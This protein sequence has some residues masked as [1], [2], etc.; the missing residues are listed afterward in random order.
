MSLILLSHSL[1]PTPLNLLKIPDC[2]PILPSV[3]LYSQLL[4]FM[5]K[6]YSVSLQTEQILD[7]SL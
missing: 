5:F 6:E 3:I 1:I 4:H 7:F 2:C